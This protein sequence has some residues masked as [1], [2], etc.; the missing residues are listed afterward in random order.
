MD[1]EK[2][3]QRI[4]DHV[5]AEGRVKAAALSESFDVSIE[6]IR[7]DLLDLQE[8]GIL[9]RVHGGARAR[10]IERESAYQRR[11]A[12]NTEEKAA[13]AAK[14]I[15]EIEDGSTIYLDYGTTTYALASELVR[16][17]RSLTV[18]TNALPI[19]NNLAEAADIEILVLGGYFRRNEFSLYGPVGEKAW[20]GIYVDAGFFGAAGIHPEAGMTNH[21]PLEVA[22]TQKALT[23]CRTVTA[24]ADSSKLGVI[25]VHQVS[26]LDQL[27]LLITDSSPSPIIE[28]S[29][30]DAG[31]D[32]SIA[33]ENN[34]GIH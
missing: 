20:A 34:H 14:A 28:E 31:V 15:H 4:A 16:A 8:A 7:K 29:L 2:R 19:A 27:D 30:S 13:I 33:K 18:V 24:L 12:V 6:T 21:H 22:V 11:R 3:Q 5:L 10:R 26:P 23:H 17:G 32:I 25:A 1:L 9:E